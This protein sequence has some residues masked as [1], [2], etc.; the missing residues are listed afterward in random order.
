MLE[1]FIDNIFAVVRGQVF[2]QS[3]GISMGTNSA[4]LLAD[5]FLYSNHMRQNSSKSFYKRKYLA[6]AFI[7]TLR[8]VDVLSINNNQF[9]TYVHSIYPNELE[10]HDRVFHI[11][12]VFRYII[13]IGYKR[14]MK[15]STL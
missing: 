13:V 5:L 10:I 12:F 1:F 3:V 2:Q 6:V 8:Y 11:C 4:L 7:L 15:D 9:H 14:Q